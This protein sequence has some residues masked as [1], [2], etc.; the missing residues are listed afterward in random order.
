MNKNTRNT[1]IF[2]LVLLGAVIVAIVL[3]YIASFRTV[4]FNFVPDDLESIT[5]YQDDQQVGF[6]DE[7]GSLRLQPSD[8]TYKPNGDRYSEATAFT[9]EGDITITVDPSYSDAY[10]REILQAENPRIVEV[11]RSSFPGIINGFTINTGTIYQKGDWYATTLTQHP[12][13]GGQQGDIYRIVLHKVDNT[14]QIATGPEIVLGAP[15]YP[16]VPYDILKDINSR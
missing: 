13:P 2:S 11:I 14:W 12:L 6:L 16:D 9:V 1:I 8:Y 7:S 10:R 3:F 5:I 4:T 15:V